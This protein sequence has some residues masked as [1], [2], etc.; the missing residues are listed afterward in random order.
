MDLKAGKK[1]L[2]ASW[3]KVAGA[4]SYTVYVSTKQKSGYK[5]VTTTKKESYKITK[6]GKKKLSSNKKYY[7]YVV[8]N[9]KVG[10]TTYKS[11]ADYCWYL[12][13]K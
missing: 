1:T 6:Y 9:T 2:T 5:K 8:A 12:K 13:T 7:V 11:N 4:T 10:K 3:K